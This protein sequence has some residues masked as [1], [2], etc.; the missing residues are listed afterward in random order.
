[1]FSIIHNERVNFYF[2][3][4]ISNFVDPGPLK[5]RNSLDIRINTRLSQLNFQAIRRTNGYLPHFAICGV[6][7]DGITPTVDVGP[8]LASIY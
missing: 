2:Q 8:A 4:F 3:P 1:M 5:C 6:N 7:D